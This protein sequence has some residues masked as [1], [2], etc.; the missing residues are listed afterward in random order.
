MRLVADS[1]YM[2]YYIMNN[3]I[4][5]YISTIDI[6][7]G[8]SIRLDCPMCS[9]TKTLS[10]TRFND[11]TKFYCFH[12]NCSKG[13][14]IKEGITETSFS[15]VEDILSPPL[16]VGLEVEKQNWRRN[17]GSKLFYEYIKVNHCT[18]AWANNLAD[19][20]YDY[21]RDRAVFIIKS[22]NKIVDAAGRYLGTRDLR[23]DFSGPKWYRYGN[24]GIPF[25]CGNSKHAVIVEDCASACSISSF[26]T[27][28][29]LLGTSLSEKVLDILGQFDRVTVAL[30]KDA[31]TKSI[32]ML[33][34]IS[35][36]T[37]NVEMVVL[38]RDLKKLDVLESKKVLKI[39]D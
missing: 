19:I 15:V 28:V 21:K 10:V 22:S 24:S 17:N 35:W 32:D 26:A 36:E 37:N 23:G 8:I 16:Q 29:A 39:D 4:K 9:G 5:D 38:E 33:T 2:E 7:I 12:A 13:G 11:S 34:R 6:D 18:H 31:T 30:D 25:I 20:R 1:R 27:G 3:I 14:I